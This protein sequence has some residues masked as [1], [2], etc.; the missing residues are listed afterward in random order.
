MGDL[1]VERDREIEQ[2]RRTFEEE[3]E[4]DLTLSNL[5]KRHRDIEYKVRDGA[6][7]SQEEES[8]MSEIYQEILRV[9]IQRLQF[10]QNL[11]ESGRANSYTFSYKCACGLE[12]SLY[13]WD[14]DWHLKHRPRCPECGDCKMLTRWIKP[15]VKFISEINPMG[16]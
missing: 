7:L 12:F 5:E 10:Q 11:F 15:T 1:D 6:H 9:R 3:C 13:S 16:L 4:F 8:Q 2:D 14:R